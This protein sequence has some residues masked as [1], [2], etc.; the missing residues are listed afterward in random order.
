MRPF[1]SERTPHTLV[2]PGAVRD[3]SRL[4]STRKGE[5]RQIEVKKGHRET[6]RSF[7]F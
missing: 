7:S 4:A 6:D 2:A 1:V 3:K 5:R